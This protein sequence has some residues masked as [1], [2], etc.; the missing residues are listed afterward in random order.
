MKTEKPFLRMSIMAALVLGLGGLAGVR[1][2][3]AHEDEWAQ[4]VDPTD[5][6]TGALVLDLDDDASDEAWA[7]ARDAIARGV[8]PLPFVVDDNPRTELGELVSDEAELY[9]VNVPA[10]ERDD[11][12]RELS[13]LAETE[14]TEVERTWSLPRGEGFVAFTP[15]EGEASASDADA[16][17]REGFTPNDPYFRNQWHMDQIGM[18]RA[19]ERGC[20]EGS[21][22]AVIDTGVAHRDADGFRRAPDLADTRFVPGWDFVGN[23]ANADDEHGHGT[24][25][26]GTI[27]QSTNNGVGVAGVAPGALIMPI[28]VLD[29]NGSGNWA[30]IAGG[31]RWAADHGAHVINMSLGGGSASRVVERAIQYAHDHGVVVIAAAGNAGRAPV[32]YPAR[33][34]HVIAVSAVRF[35]GQITPYSSRGG[36]LD[37]AAPG[38]DLRVDQNGD[39]LPDGVFQNTLVGGDPTRFDYLAWQGTSMAAPHVAGVAALVRATGVTDP[40]AI[41]RILLESAQPAGASELYGAGIVRADQ[42]LSRSTESRAQT[43][44]A[45]ALGLSGLVLVTLARRRRLGLAHAWGAAALAFLFA[46]GL[47]W[48]PLPSLVGAGISEALSDGVAG[49][50]AWGTA[51]V[52]LLAALPAAAILIF[53]QRRSWHLALVGLALAASAGLVVEALDPTVSLLGGWLAGPA[54]IAVAAVLAL[55]ARQVARSDKP[56]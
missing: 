49:I 37:I 38:G 43:R 46:G 29:A 39:G 42:A 21:V 53:Q 4:D 36:G 5:P 15:S 40:A 11:V 20:G 54:L 27:A 13:A 19:W 26:A 45:W 44:S 25:V 17:D 7:H 34:E 10:S 3:E 23:D 30:G 14:A 51:G 48:L 16:A 28:R 2:M 52:A 9:R 24:H 6:A 8:A 50:S 55:L 12:L 18:R 1:R 32:E 56:V 47:G 31:I 41:E 33:H 35:D 22:V